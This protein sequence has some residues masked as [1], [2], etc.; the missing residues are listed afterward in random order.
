[1][2]H[3]HKATSQVLVS[4][5][6]RVSQSCIFSSSGK[7]RSSSISTSSVF[8]SPKLAVFGGCA[9][10]FPND[11][12]RLKIAKICTSV[13][14][15]VAT[16]ALSLHISLS[17]LLIQFLQRPIFFQQKSSHVVNRQLKLHHICTLLLAFLDIPWITSHNQS[18]VALYT[19]RPK[20]KTTGGG[21]S[22]RTTWKLFIS[23]LVIVSRVPWT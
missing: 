19:S 4:H 12:G 9:V 20:S 3:V 22:L 6:G 21:R 13:L 2:I 17:F 11:A 1:M 5:S 23:F 10:P 16:F 14:V 8:A 15:L 18:T 7:C